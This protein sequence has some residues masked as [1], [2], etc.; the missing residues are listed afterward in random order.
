MQCTDLLIDFSPTNIVAI[1]NFF[2][3]HIVSMSQRFFSSVRR[4]HEGVHVCSRQP[5]QPAL[6]P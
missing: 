3:V 1:N 6:H 2:L 4:L 5:V